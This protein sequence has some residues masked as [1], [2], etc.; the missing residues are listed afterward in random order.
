[1]NPHIII[2]AWSFYGFSSE[3]NGKTDHCLAGTRLKVKK[4]GWLKIETS[5]GTKDFNPG[6]QVIVLDVAAVA[7][8]GGVQRLIQNITLAFLHELCHWA[9]DIHRPGR[10]HAPLWNEFLANVINQTR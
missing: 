1:M 7:G 6:D 5:W 9:E 4:N 3:C 8:Y 2:D 10:E